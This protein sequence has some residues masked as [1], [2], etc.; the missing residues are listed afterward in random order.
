MVLLRRPRGWTT[1]Q[2][3]V[4]RK[5]DGRVW[6]AALLAGKGCLSWPSG[7]QKQLPLIAPDR[8]RGPQGLVIQI[9][10]TYKNAPWPHIDRLTFRMFNSYL[11]S[12]EKAVTNSL[13]DS[14]WHCSSFFPLHSPWCEPEGTGALEFPRW[15]SSECPFDLTQHLVSARG[16]Q[17][18][19]T[20]PWWLLTWIAVVTQD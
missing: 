1:F 6:H 18:L 10:I 2:R 19:T 16:T 3:P 4:G 13:P 7:C 11:R 8:Q 14:R 12:C 9:T 17:S 5:Q 15:N 20:G